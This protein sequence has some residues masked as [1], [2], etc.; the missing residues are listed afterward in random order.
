MSFQTTEVDLRALFEPFGQV[1]RVHLGKDR[2]TGR[3][4]GFAFVEMANDDEAAKAMAALNGKEFGGRALKVNEAAPK[5]DRPS[6]PRGPG[7]PGGPA[8]AA[9]VAA[10]GG[11]SRPRITG[12]RCASL[13]NRAGKRRT[14]VRGLQVSPHSSF[15]RAVAG[16][17][18][19]AT[20]SPETRRIC[21]Y[22]YISETPK[23]DEKAGKTEDEG[24]APRA[25]KGG[26]PGRWRYRRILGAGIESTVRANPKSPTS[27]RKA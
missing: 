27:T 9:A 2:E 11:D 17:R 20:L 18:R 19:P 7:G 6:G 5:G 10:A 3:S 23:R 24:G 16:S 1:T 21:V 12:T 25:E 14:F 15:S 4:R 26:R 22:H 13:A 8:A